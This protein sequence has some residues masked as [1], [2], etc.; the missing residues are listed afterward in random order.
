MR[1]F[2][3]VTRPKLLEKKIISQEPLDI[4]SPKPGE[5]Y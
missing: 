1:R 3:S 4:Q 2:L 5:V